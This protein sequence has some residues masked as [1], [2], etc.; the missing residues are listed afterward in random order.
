MHNGK[1][2]T[3]CKGLYVYVYVYTFAITNK[4]NK[5]STQNVGHYGAEN[6][7]YIYQL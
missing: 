7:N 4:T 3:S 2:D 1:I 6:K 5:T